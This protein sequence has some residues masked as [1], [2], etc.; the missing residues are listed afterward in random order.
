MLPSM[1][2]SP[3]MTMTERSGRTTRRSDTAIMVRCMSSTHSGIGSRCRTSVPRTTR[4]STSTPGLAGAVR[5]AQVLHRPDEGLH[6]VL[7]V[8]EVEARP[9]IVV[10]VRGDDVALHEFLGESAAVARR[11]GHGGAAALV[12]R[13]RNARPADFFQ[14]LH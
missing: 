6:I 2:R 13:R 3:G 11:N 9:D 4:I 12:L 14:S 10:A 5:S 8:V 1:P 7:V